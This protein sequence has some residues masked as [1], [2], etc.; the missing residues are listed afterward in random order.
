MSVRARR[1]FEFLE[2]RLAP[3]DT[4]LV[5]G[6]AAMAASPPETPLIAPPIA[7]GIDKGTAC[8]ILSE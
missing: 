5:I 6:A 2:A 4:L 1:R 3:S 7:S 8:G